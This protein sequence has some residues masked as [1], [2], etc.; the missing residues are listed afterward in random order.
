MKKVRIEDTDTGN[1]K[2]YECSAYIMAL[3]LAEK[4]KVAAQGENGEVAAL[5]SYLCAG[6]YAT[7]MR[8]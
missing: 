6:I 1:I 4:D 3:K 7:L 8:G 2:E 5:L